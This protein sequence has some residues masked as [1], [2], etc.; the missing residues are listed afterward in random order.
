MGEYVI[1]IDTFVTGC[2]RL[3]GSARSL[4]IHMMV[5]ESRWTMQRFTDLLKDFRTDFELLQ[6]GLRE[7]GLLDKTSPSTSYGRHRPTV[8]PRASLISGT[9]WQRQVSSSGSSHM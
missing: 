5:F 4:D 6:H 1:D 9:D 8:R 7:C 3:R 2:L